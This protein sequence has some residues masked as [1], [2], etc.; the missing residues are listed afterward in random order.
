[1]ALVQAAGGT[2]NGSTWLD[3]TNYYETLPVAP[4]RARA[5]A[6]GG[7]DGHA[8][9]RPEPGEPRQPARGREE[10][11]ALVATTTGPYGSWYEKLAGPSLPARASRTTTPRSARWTTSTR[12]R[13]RTCSAFFRD[14]LRPEQRGPVGRRRRRSRPTI[15]RW[16]ERYFGGIP[17][18][19]DIPPLGDLSPAADPR[20]G[21]SRDR[22]RPGPAA[23]GL[24]R[25]P[26]ARRSATRGSTP[27]TS[28]SRSSPAARARGSTAASSATSGS[29]RT[30]RCSPSASSAARRSAPAGRRSGRA[31]PSSGS[32]RPSSRSWS[33]SPR[34]RSVR[35]R[36]GPRPGADRDRG[37]RRRCRASRSAPT[38][39]RCTR[40]CSTTRT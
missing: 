38:G 7:P 30:S 26:G 22:S 33:A 36:A 39:S 11:E 10:R 24:R 8:A 28:P 32:R 37:A 27:S 18:N 19:P 12:P 40:P 31:S 6:R 23:A 35:R 2:M 17:A 25:V 34:G 9:R 14:L 15:R 16:T 5:V 13:S 4:G 29:P 1:M 3:R 21:A 20:R